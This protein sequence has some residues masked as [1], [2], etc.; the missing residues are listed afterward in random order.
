MGDFTR[1][2]GLRGQQI[3]MLYLGGSEAK[4]T[5]WTSRAFAGHC[6][7]DEPFYVRSA[8]W[9]PGDG[10]I[11]VDGQAGPFNLN[12]IAQTPFRGSV[13]VKHLDVASTGFVD[14][15]SGITGLI[16]FSGTVA[17]NGRVMNTTGK[18]TATGVRL[19][20]GAATSTQI[21]PCSIFTGKLRTSSAQRSNVPPLARS[22][23]A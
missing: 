1:A 12:D 17:S 23:R 16:D 11:S 19:L 15:A 21:S 6:A 18:A 20:P 8:S 7:H 22:K 10:K 3:F 4:V 13:S 5:G 9:S 2:G 14:P